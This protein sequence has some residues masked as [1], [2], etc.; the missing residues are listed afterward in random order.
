[1][2]PEKAQSFI[3]VTLLPI[4]TEISPVHPPKAYSPIEI[5]LLGI[6]KDTRLLQFSNLQPIVYQFVMIKMVEK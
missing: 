1:M 3:S 4:E 5:T 6:E 2:Q